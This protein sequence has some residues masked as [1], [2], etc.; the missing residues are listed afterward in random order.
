MVAVSS[1]SFKRAKSGS[2]SSLTI[3]AIADC[4][5]L[6]ARA[7]L[8]ILN[9]DEARITRAPS[10]CHRLYLV[11]YVKRVFCTTPLGDYF[12]LHRRRTKS[13]LQHRHEAIRAIPSA[14]AAT[15]TRIRYS[16][17]IRPFAVLRRRVIGVRVTAYFLSQLSR[18]WH[19]LRC[20]RLS[21][22]F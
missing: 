11:R 17:T 16:S 9:I 8:S 19:F 14:A 13:D 12:P 21:A 22:F 18:G 2:S 3:L 20:C 1:S 6:G 15:E 7:S 4:G 10:R 5:Q